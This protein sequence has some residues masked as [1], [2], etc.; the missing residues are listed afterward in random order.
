MTRTHSNV[1]RRVFEQFTSSV[2]AVALTALVLM[3]SDAR[4]ADASIDPSAAAQ[5]IAVRF[6]SQAL[7][8]SAEATRVYKTLKRVSRQVCGFNGEKLSLAETA[9]AQRCVDETLAAAV[10]RIDRPKLTALHATGN[11]AVG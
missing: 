8:N 1:L 11:R 6:S 9:A 2:G 4:A 10:K 3:A 5:S 7:D